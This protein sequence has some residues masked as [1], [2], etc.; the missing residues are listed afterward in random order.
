MYNNCLL[1]RNLYMKKCAELIDERALTQQKIEE[2]VQLTRK[3]FK[4]VFPFFNIKISFYNDKLFFVS[5]ETAQHS[6]FFSCF[7]EY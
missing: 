1:F 2:Q 4:Q 5:K 3:Q 7:I 6:Y